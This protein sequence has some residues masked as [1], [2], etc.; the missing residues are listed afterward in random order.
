ML[1]KN[2]VKAMLVGAV[3]V[4][5][6]QAGNYD[7]P[8]KPTDLSLNSTTDWQNLGDITWTWNDLNTDGAINPNEVVT[9]TIE[10]EK[11]KTGRHLF[12]ALKVWQGDDVVKTQSWNV[13]VVSNTEAVVNTTYTTS[14]TF[15]PD[16]VGTYDFTARVTC[17]DDLSKVAKD[18]LLGATQPWGTS[19][20]FFDNNNQW[21]LNTS[22]YTWGG[23]TYTTQWYSETSLDRV[24]TNDWNS[25]GKD[26]KL[27]Q[28]DTKKFQIV[29]VEKEVPEPGSL[30]LM[31]L[32]LTSLAGAFFMRRKNK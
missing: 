2:A 20:K 4:G 3:M 18:S 12:D 31:F 9:F 29:V 6:A 14:F 11:Y 17:S 15:T 24:T 30:S 28:G 21:T 13:P 16:A 25:W 10:V 32:G 27:W 22:N 26:T 5:M 8:V 7:N 23:H 1:N 19:K